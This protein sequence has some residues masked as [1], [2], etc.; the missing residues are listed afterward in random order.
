MKRTLPGHYIKLDVKRKK[1]EIQKY[2]DIFKH[3][4]V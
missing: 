2:W 4:T 3:Y 1:F